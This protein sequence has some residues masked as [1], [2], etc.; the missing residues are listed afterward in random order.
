MS[1]LGVNI[2]RDPER[3]IT[4]NYD[5]LISKL[6]SD[7]SRWSLLPFLSIL[8]R[9]EALKINILQRLLFLFQ[10]IPAKYLSRRILQNDFKVYLA[11]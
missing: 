8:Q 10:T 11:G 4:S 7:L 2:P 1:Y 3:I 9:V 5:P 6:K